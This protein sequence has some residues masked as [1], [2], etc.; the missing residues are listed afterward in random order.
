LKQTIVVGEDIDALFAEDR[1][2]PSR[3]STSRASSNA[4]D[5]V[6]AA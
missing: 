1:S 5:G 6:G 3:P 4:L 2:T